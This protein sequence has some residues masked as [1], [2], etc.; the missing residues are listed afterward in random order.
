DGEHLAVAGVHRGGRTCRTARSGT[1]PA[2]FSSGDTTTI[3]AFRSMDTAGQPAS[4]LGLPCPLWGA[5]GPCDPLSPRGQFRLPGAGGPASGLQCIADHGAAGSC[6]GLAGWQ[7][8]SRHWRR[9]GG[10]VVREAGGDRT[11]AQFTCAGGGMSWN[12]GTHRVVDR[13]NSAPLSGGAGVLAGPWGPTAPFLL[14]LGRAP[15]P[16]APP[17][18]TPGPH[19]SSTPH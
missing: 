5:V 11:L 10:M 1:G 19:C 6:R 12:A 15:L 18:P 13:T 9:G 16:P 3:P 14:M 2:A 7:A 4:R 8:R 17:F